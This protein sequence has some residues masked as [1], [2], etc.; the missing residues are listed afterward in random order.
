MP[1]S[2]DKHD[3]RRQVRDSGKSY[4]QLLAEPGKHNS[5]R[6][7]SARPVHLSRF[8]TGSHRPDM[9]RLLLLQ[10]LWRRQKLGLGRL[11]VASTANSSIGHLYVQLRLD[12]A[13][14]G[15]ELGIPLL[16]YYW[17][18]ENRR[19]AGVG[20]RL[21]AR[22]EQWLRGSGHDI[23]AVAVDPADRDAVRLYVSLDFRL[24]YETDSYRNE[25][26]P[27]GSSIRKPMTL[28]IYFKEYESAGPGSQGSVMR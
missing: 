5:V 25:F 12:P 18:R 11:F 14:P 1:H 4:A 7:H 21:V 17:V 8:F 16:T 22:A 20:R 2:R 3:L 24:G 26:R 13:D 9:R 15:R 23:A 10:D 6:I 28:A 19:G 27:G